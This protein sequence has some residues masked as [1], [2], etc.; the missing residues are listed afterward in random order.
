LKKCVRIANAIIHGFPAR[1]PSRPI[2]IYYRY[3]SKHRFDISEML[4][5]TNLIL[6]WFFKH[7]WE[8][9]GWG[10]DDAKGIAKVA[11]RMAGRR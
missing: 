4:V 2:N 1:A 8:D 5:V 7:G 6:L 9:P 11:N 3:P 10:R